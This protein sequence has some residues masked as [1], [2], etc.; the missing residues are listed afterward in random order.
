MTWQA[1]SSIFLPVAARSLPGS[2]RGPV[3]VPR[4]VTSMTTV[5]P[6]TVSLS[7]LALESGRALAQ[8]FQA[9]RTSSYALDS[10]LRRDLVV[11]HVLRE[12]L[13]RSPPVLVVV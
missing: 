12:S 3:C 1:R 10:A 4:Q 7:K 5:L 6:L 9:E 11:D 8:P 2:C 13:F